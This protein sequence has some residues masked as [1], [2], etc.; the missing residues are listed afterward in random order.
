MRHVLNALQAV[1]FAVGT[2]LLCSSDSSPRAL[3]A[4]AGGLTG[5]C[6]CKAFW[7]ACDRL[8]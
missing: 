4:L 8:P 3:V 5:F 1:C 7:D 6:L 2:G